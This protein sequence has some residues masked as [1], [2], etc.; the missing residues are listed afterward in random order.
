MAMTAKDAQGAQAHRA[1]KS[2]EAGEAIFE[3]SDVHISMRRIAM[4]CQ[5]LDIE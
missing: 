3:G 5:E 1:I 4:P 2:G